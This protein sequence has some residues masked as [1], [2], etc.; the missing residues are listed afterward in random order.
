MEE[1]STLRFYTSNQIVIQIGISSLNFTHIQ[2]EEQKHYCSH[3]TQHQQLL[4]H[5]VKCMLQMLI[6]A[7]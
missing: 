7:V 5:I 2:Q 6:I 3:L 1:V 4:M